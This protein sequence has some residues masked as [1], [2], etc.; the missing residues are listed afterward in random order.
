MDVT[1][2]DTKY[3]YRIKSL[4][5]LLYI[6]NNP[7]ICPRTID[8]NILKKIHKQITEI[9]SMIGMA[10]LKTTIFHQIIYFIQDLVIDD[11]HEYLHTVIIGPPGSGK[12]LA[13]DTKLLMYDGSIKN[14]QDVQIN[15]LLMGDDSTPRTVLS[16]CQGVDEC[17][18]IN[19]EFLSPYIVNSS[20]ILSLCCKNTFNTIDIPVLEYIKN[21]DTLY[22]TFR[23]YKVSVNIPCTVD[24]LIDPYILGY[25][26]DSNFKNYLSISHQSIIDYFNNKLGDKF[27]NYNGCYHINPSYFNN[28]STDLSFLVKLGTKSLYLV[29]AG[30]R[31]AL[32]NDNNLYIKKD[33]PVFDIVIFLC[34]ILNFE[35]TYK[36]SDINININNID[37]EKELM[38][39][40]VCFDKDFPSLIYNDNKLYYTPRSDTKYTFHDIDITRVPVQEYYGFELSKNGRFLLQD[41]TVTHNTTIAHLIGELYKN[42]GILS[43]NGEFKIA[44]REDFI[45]E[46]LGQ[47]SIKTKKLLESCLGGILFIDEVYALGPGKNDHDSFSKEAID[48]L[49]VFLSEYSNNFCCII[50]GYEDD[51]KNCF[52]SINAGL[53]R[54][55]Q[56]VHRIE[57]YTIKDLSEMFFKHIN[58]IRWTTNIKENFI[59][60]ILEKNKK[61]FSFTGGDIN[62]LITK[63]KIAHSLRLINDDGVIKFLLT[64]DD[65]LLAI[66]HMKSQ[67]LY[68]EENLSHNSMYI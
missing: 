21:K 46:Y 7:S 10:Q 9:N 42:L 5:D 49:N 11:E 26:I 20:H 54:R 43:L 58:E 37:Y 67:R 52:F 8:L 13:K 12:C 48:T 44:K 27:C 34:N 63:C 64:E 29:L 3:K 23:G 31:D 2:F 61:L 62:N 35:F 45:A 50:A 32:F 66:E 30:L 4:D 25:C 28:S 16:I 36:I 41:C 33:N 17:F 68:E 38:N 39:L 19:R 14:V 59:I 18:Q 1:T 24:T 65:L 53:A 60:Q 22:Q 47:T 15:D 6:L 40:T 57:D 55:F 51:I 56:W